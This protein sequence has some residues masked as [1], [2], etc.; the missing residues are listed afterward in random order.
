MPDHLHAIVAVTSS[1]QLAETVR[2]WKRYTARAQGLRWQRDFF[3]HRLRAGENLEL[4]ARYI[5]EN[6]L[7]A[8]LVARPEDWPHVIDFTTVEEGP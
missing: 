7:R 4:K 2:G 5:R 3:D 8:G 6:P 1:G